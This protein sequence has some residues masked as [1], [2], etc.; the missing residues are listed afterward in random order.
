LT[1]DEAAV[2]NGNWAR[3]KVGIGS[4]HIRIK[5][6]I[7]YAE[8][9]AVAFQRYAAAKRVGADPVAA[10]LG[11]Y[12]PKTNAA[13]KATAFVASTFDRILDVVERLYNG[14]AKGT[15][16]STRAIFERARRGDLAQADN[17]EGVGGTSPGSGM[18]M[19]QRPAVDHGWRTASAFKEP[20]RGSG[21]GDIASPGPSPGQLFDE[22][23]DVL[24][25]SDPRTGMTRGLTGDAVKQAL[26]GQPER[27]LAE[28]AQLA[29]ARV[30]DLNSRI[31]AVKQRAATEG[32]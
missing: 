3:I 5:K 20:L 25:D 17:W 14:L 28:A 4:G 7:A 13:Q 18:D 30:A 32:C 27:A 10:M 31:E 12:S 8:S 2:L 19:M 22:I 6:P 9:Q 15:F 23:N 21:F 29:E 26:N 1:P 24:G 16:D 11:G